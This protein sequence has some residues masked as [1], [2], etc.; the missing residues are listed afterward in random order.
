MTY[1][2]IKTMLSS[3]GLPVAYDAFPIG[4]VPSLPYIVY[5]YPNSENFGGDNQ[6]YK[7]GES[8]RAWLCT[9]EKDFKTEALVESAF[10]T[11]HLYWEKT[12]S[13]LQSDAM[14]MILYEMETLI[15]D[16]QQS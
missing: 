10:N 16:E 7:K 14:Y 8:I 6:V 1:S 11:Y 2:E 13:F 3:T 5:S 4:A 9:A 15:E 12:E